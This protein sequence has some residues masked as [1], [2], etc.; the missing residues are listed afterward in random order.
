MNTLI[1][2]QVTHAG[3]RLEDVVATRL[4]LNVLFGNVKRFN[5]RDVSIN[6]KWVF[7]FPD[8]SSLNTYQKHLDIVVRQKLTELMVQYACI[9]SSKDYERAVTLLKTQNSGDSGEYTYEPSGFIF[10]TNVDMLP[11]R[12]WTADHF[13]NIWISKGA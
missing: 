10:L 13:V 8:A 3:V 12:M 7:V 2:K 1:G 9:N 5:D 11:S 4:V 6:D